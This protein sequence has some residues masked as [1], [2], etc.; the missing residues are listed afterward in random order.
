MNQPKS[1][2]RRYAVFGPGGLKCGCCGPG[3]GPYKKS[4]LR[5]MKKRERRMS[6]T[7]LV[8]ESNED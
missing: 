8:R 7:E 4:E 5:R 3:A 2:Y 1:L 6:F